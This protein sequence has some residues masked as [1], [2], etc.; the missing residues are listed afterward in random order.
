MLLRQN[1]Q[2]DMPTKGART[3][4]YTGQQPDWLIWATV[5]KMRRQE[6]QPE[7]TTVAIVGL[8]S[9]A[10]CAASLRPAIKDT[11]PCDRARILCEDR[12]I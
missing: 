5:G 9:V 4:W 11:G 1:W 7:N 3:T 8:P 12:W 10:Q 6:V 2:K